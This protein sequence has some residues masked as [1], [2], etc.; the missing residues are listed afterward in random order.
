MGFLLSFHATRYKGVASPSNR[1]LSP[2]H[3]PFPYIDSP[4]E[5]LNFVNYASRGRAIVQTLTYYK[6]DAT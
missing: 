6:L 4:A 5:V 3:S 2:P 1:E